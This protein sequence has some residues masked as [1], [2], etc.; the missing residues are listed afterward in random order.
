MS[1]F[2]DFSSSVPATFNSSSELA[3][4]F[5]RLLLADGLKT[6]S[7]QIQKGWIESKSS[8]MWRT[9]GPDTLTPSVALGSVALHV[10]EDQDP[11]PQGCM[12]ST[13][14]CFSKFCEPEA[15]LVPAGWQRRHC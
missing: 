13:S 14:S 10:L 6:D 11:V 15:V 2:P 9:D 4:S 8:L 12:F 5:F 3:R 1:Q 7:K